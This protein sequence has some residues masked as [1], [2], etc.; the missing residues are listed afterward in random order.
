M[1]DASSPCLVDS[2]PCK[3][4]NADDTLIRKVTPTERTRAGR[5]TWSGE[6]RIASHGKLQAPSKGQPLDSSHC[7]F[8]STLH[9]FAE[10]VIDPVDQPA[11]APSKVTISLKCSR[12]FGSLALFCYLRRPQQGLY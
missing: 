4:I 7:W 8:R 6:A 10:L 1:P 9:Q 12:V 3:V 2:H 11:K 5:S